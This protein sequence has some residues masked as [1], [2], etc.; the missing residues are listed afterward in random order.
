[1]TSSDFECKSFSACPVSKDDHSCGSVLSPVV[2]F[3]ARGASVVNVV[4]ALVVVAVLG[5][6]V[7]VACVTVGA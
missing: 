6:T 5:V 3:G 7:G 1:M 2:V 4:V